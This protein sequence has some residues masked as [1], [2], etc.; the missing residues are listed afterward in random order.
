VTVSLAAG[1]L[2]LDLEPELGGSVG[3]FTLARPGGAFDLMRPL[4]G[5]RQSLRAGMFPM[6]P[7]ANCIRDN[8]FTIAGRHYRVAPNMAGARLNFHGSGW[9]SAWQPDEVT[10]TRAVLHLP[11]GRVDDIYRYEAIQ[12]FSLD[13][14][15]L[16]VRLEV[17]NRGADPMPF[18]FG[19]HPWF[20][21]HGDGRARFAA[22]TV[23]RCDPEGQV[24]GREAVTA[25]TDY[26]RSR[27]PPTEYVNVCYAGWDGTAT[28]DWPA[29]GVRLTLEADPV[30][31]H[32]ML[33]VPQG[34]EPVFCLEPQSN[35]P[36]G[37]DGLE[38]GATPPG[39]HILDSGGRLA[40]E[41]RFGVEF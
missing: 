30:F 26:G 34:G 36:C 10:P 29:A 40:G 24:I 8:A 28:V 21:N 11:D 2:R 19:L 31:Q 12:T 37:F 16:R 1:A 27:R 22:T 6:L 4:R 35:P 25:A 9:L 7:F 3:S 18:S 33:H 23:V 39:V 20:P 13:P 41:L 14:A 15:G 38:S 5:A 17:I 32:L